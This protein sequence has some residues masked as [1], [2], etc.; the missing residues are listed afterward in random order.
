MKCKKYAKII[1]IKD[2][3]LHMYI[4]TKL[5]I[6]LLGNLSHNMKQIMVIINKI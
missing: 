3:L 5:K 2:K 6:S 4:S 1:N